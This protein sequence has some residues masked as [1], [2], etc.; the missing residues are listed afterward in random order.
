MS[1]GGNECAKD[2]KQDTHDFS[3]D[4]HILSLTYTV[5][6]SEKEK[7]AIKSESANKVVMVS[8]FIKWD[9]TQ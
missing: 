1:R 4:V 2:T 3:T 9:D 7:W 8:M 5:N 6:A